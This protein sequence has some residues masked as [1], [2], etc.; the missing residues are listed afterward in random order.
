VTLLLIVSLRQVGD[1]LQRSGT[2]LRRVDLVV[3]VR[4]A[5]RDGGATVALGG[6]KVREVAAQHRLGGDK[7]DVARRN[8]M[9]VRALVAGKEEH[10]VADDRTAGGAPPL[11]SRQARGH[12]P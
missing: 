5:Q 10:L 7:R 8:L 9:L 1:E 11:G 4:R 2:E 3:H 6:S 12:T